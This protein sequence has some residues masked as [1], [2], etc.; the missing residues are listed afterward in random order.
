MA[1]NF[2]KYKGRLLDYLALKNIKVENGMCRCFNPSH[3]DKNPSCKVTKNWFQCYGCGVKGDIYDAT[4][5]IDNFPPDIKKQYDFLEKLFEKS[6]KC[7]ICGGV[8]DKDWSEEEA[9]AQ[10]E[11]VFPGKP[12]AECD[13]VCDD[14]YKM[15]M[16]NEEAQNA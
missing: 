6:Y 2:E 9:L 4:R 5:L 8:F 15:V 1:R 14:C 12:L 7:A 10:K 11:K 16:G 13:L 3:E